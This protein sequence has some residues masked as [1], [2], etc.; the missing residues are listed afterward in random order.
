MRTIANFLTCFALLP[1]ALA[2]ISF[3][4]AFILGLILMCGIPQG[5]GDTFE[6]N[7]NGRF[8]VAENVINLMYNAASVLPWSILILSPLLIIGLIGRR[9][10]QKDIQLADTNKISNLIEST[11]SFVIYIVTIGV[12]LSLLF[13]SF[14]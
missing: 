10:T 4:A 9:L 2:V 11:T 6:L 7:C 5:V 8:P 14:F 1:L 12:I 3:I 13:S